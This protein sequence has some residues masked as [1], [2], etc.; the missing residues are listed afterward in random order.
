MERSL[1]ETQASDS[2]T[3]YVDN[4]DQ[5]AWPSRSAEAKNQPKEREE[6]LS[7]ENEHMHESGKHSLLDSIVEIEEVG[8]PKHQRPC[9][10]GRGDQDGRN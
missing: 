7:E 2:P 8:D 6:D 5:Q 4:A 9:L 3:K 10:Q 1:H